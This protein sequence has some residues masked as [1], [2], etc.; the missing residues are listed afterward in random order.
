MF[1]GMWGLEQL[2]NAHYDEVYPL[3]VD[4]EGVIIDLDT[5]ESYRNLLPKYGR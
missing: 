3:E 5:P 4:D 2:L 1:R